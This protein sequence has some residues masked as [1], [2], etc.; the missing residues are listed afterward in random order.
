M[1][2]KSPNANTV[3]KL[4]ARINVMKANNYSFKELGVGTI[5]ENV[6]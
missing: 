6:F 2:A 1:A 4:E 5:F 3:A